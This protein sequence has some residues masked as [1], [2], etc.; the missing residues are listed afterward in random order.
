MNN[1]LERLDRLWSALAT[2]VHEETCKKAWRV[3]R[4][5][6]IEDE[7]L[8]EIKYL[9]SLISTARQFILDEEEATA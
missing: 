8:C 1:E 3:V 9:Q 6:D 4:V 7:E 2:G 5:P